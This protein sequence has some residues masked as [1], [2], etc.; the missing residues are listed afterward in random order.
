MTPLLYS[1]VWNGKYEKLLSY[2]NWRSDMVR[3]D[4]NIGNY[5]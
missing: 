4:K 5:I 1:I 2:P 3:H